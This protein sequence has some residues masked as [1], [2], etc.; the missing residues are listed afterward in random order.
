M[1]ENP[2]LCPPMKPEIAYA[3]LSDNR[4][5]DWLRL[6]LTLL[7]IFNHTHLLPEVK[8][9]GLTL[10]DTPIFHGVYWLFACHL[11]YLTVP[12]FFLFSGYLFFRDA[13]PMREGLWRE[14]LGRRVRTLL[15]PYLLWNL[16]TLIALAFGEHLFVEL[17]NGH[18][19]AVAEYSFGDWLSAFWITAKSSYSPICPPLWYMRDL[20]LVMLLA[21]PLYPLLKRTGFLLP[22]L[23]GAAWL[24]TSY[25]YAPINGFSLIA[26]F[27]FTLGAT[28]AMRRISFSPLF[29]SLRWPAT[30]GYLLLLSL[31]LFFGGHGDW[32][33]SLFNLSVIF[34]IVALSGWLTLLLERA[35][36]PAPTSWAALSFFIYAAHYYLLLLLL[37]L[38]LRLL[39][40]ENDCS[41]TLLFWALPVTTALLLT[42]IYRILHRFAPSLLSLLTGARNKK[43]A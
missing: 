41:L 33:E 26:L 12:L 22:A 18:H 38:S 7:V 43:T 1:G 13:E 39:H 23:F 32:C 15:L 36:C 14:K 25:N 10:A 40:P 31:L 16:L 42:A 24:A 19:L 2:Y 29:A 34:G 8:H 28:F 27:F 4:L 30:V 17:Q 3:P 20:M 35:Q 5:I 6:P 37:R 9:L 21:V 11:P